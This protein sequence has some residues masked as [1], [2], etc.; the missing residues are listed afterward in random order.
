MTISIPTLRTA[1]LATTLFLVSAGT[2]LAAPL[3]NP[4]NLV[5]TADSASAISLSWTDTSSKES[6]FRIER[7]TGGGSF[8]EVASVG[9]DVTGYTNTSLAAST[10]YEYR[11]RAF[12][13]ARRSTSYSGYSNIASATTFPVLPT[14]PSAP[15]T[16]YGAASSTSISLF[17]TD[18]SNNETAFV[19]ERLSEAAPVFAPIAT[20]P[21]NSTFY[22]D[23]AVTASTSYAYRVKA[24]NDAGSSAYTAT[25]D[26]TSLSE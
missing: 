17:W 12:Q 24:V 15:T 18:T 9:K 20:L 22:Y 23:I 13:T 25:F 5:A 1:L 3:S 8:V 10:T 7:R 6:G 4:T 2:A 19:V 14:P 11:V 16:L 21:T 26:I